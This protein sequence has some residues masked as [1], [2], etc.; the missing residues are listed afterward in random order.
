MRRNV[1]R[2]REKWGSTAPPLSVAFLGCRSVTPVGC[3]LGYQS[4]TPVVLSFHLARPAWCRLGGCMRSHWLKGR[5]RTWRNWATRW[6]KIRVGS[7][8]SLT[9]ELRLDRDCECFVEWVREKKK[10]RRNITLPE[11]FFRHTDTR[12]FLLTLPPPFP[13]TQ[14]PLNV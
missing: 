11:V 2:C 9:K 4:G 6:R 8:A 12:T 10:I 14:P 3:F 7:G 5:N 13:S 1:T